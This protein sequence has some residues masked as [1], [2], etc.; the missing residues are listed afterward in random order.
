MSV[1]HRRRIN[2]SKDLLGGF[3]FDSEIDL[4]TILKKIR[5]ERFLDSNFR[6]C[7]IGMEALTPLDRTPGIKMHKNNARSS[8]FPTIT[9]WY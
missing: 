4:L 2:L 9:K 3:L 8:L 1:Y 5:I 7:T 6:M